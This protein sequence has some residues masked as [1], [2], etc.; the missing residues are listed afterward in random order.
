M[1][2]ERRRGPYAP[3]ATVLQVI[4]HYR[5]RDVPETLTTTDLM[6]IGV[7]EGLLSRVMQ[8]LRFLGL[9]EEDGRTTDAFRTLRYADDDGYRV[10]LRA[11]LEHAYADIF[12]HVDPTTATIPQ[13]ERAFIPYHPGAQRPRMVTFFLALCRE[14]GIEVAS[15]P[16][17]RPTQAEGAGAP[18]RSHLRQRRTATQ[19]GAGR[20]APAA[21]SITGRDAALVAWFD[22]R[23]STNAAWPVQDRDRW[24]ATLRAIVDGIYQETE[25]EAEPEAETEPAEENG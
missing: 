9:V 13:V 25:T 2:I 1:A 5:R 4:Q 15:P 6:Q 16:K 23:P 12:G 22:S 14:A 10:A 8:A 21:P 3:P 20:Q 24:F 17:Q 11:I 7:G 19:G 18:T